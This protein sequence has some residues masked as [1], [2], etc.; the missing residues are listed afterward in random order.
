[1]VAALV[2]SHGPG[3]SAKHDVL[4]AEPPEQGR[5]KGMGQSQDL[6]F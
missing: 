1:M 6:V 3:S 2:C 5:L 4:Q